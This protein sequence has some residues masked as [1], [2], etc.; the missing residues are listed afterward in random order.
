MT[1]GS[2]SSLLSALLKI[3]HF[4]ASMST[5]SSCNTNTENQPQLTVTSSTGRT[6]NTP[7]E[8][9]RR[10]TPAGPEPSWSRTRWLVCCRRRCTAVERRQRA[11]A[12]ELQLPPLYDDHCS[13]MAA[14]WSTGNLVSLS[15]LQDLKSTYWKIAAAEIWFLK[16]LN[17]S[18][19]VLLLWLHTLSIYFAISCMFLVFFNCSFVHFIAKKTQTH[20]DWSV[21]ACRSTQIF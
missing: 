8:L 16:C 11:E 15:M 13:L 2:Y 10:R 7:G 1:D 6:S 17:I 4:S 9:P 5:S 21:E 20:Q 14:I 19:K 18:H 12:V 3:S